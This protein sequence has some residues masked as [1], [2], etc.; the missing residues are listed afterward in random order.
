MWAIL[1]VAFWQQAGYTSPQEVK[2][3][4]LKKQATLLFQDAAATELPYFYNGKIS[5]KTLIEF[6]IY[7][8][9][10]RSIRPHSKGHFEAIDK[11]TGHCR[12]SA[13]YVA[14]A[15]RDCFGRSVHNESITGF[16]YR[17]G[18][19]FG[20]N[21]VFEFVWETKI[22]NF[23]LFK[24]DN[25]TYTAYGE[26]TNMLGVTYE[27]ARKWNSMKKS[28]LELKRVGAGCKARFIITG[29]SPTK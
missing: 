3:A 16:N 7:Y 26:F 20:Y 17:K 29:W 6:G 19:Y 21:D 13:R 14:S 23:K 24:N 25:G 2:D 11:R 18:Y 27:E 8:N 12:L 4:P 1:L 5:N 28:R 9:A 10:V 15:V 22:K